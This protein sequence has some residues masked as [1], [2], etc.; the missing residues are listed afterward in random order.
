M[1]DVEPALAA[2]GLDHSLVVAV[3]FER[4]MAAVG[5]SLV[6]AQICRQAGLSADDTLVEL[7]SILNGDTQIS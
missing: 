1:A 2:A 6:S 4:Q 5:A 3:D 7:R